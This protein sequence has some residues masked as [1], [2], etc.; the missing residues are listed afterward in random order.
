MLARDNCLHLHLQP[1]LLRTHKKVI[2]QLLTE[3]MLIAI[4]GI[5]DVLVRMSAKKLISV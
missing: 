2:I 1:R 5:A 4:P 3:A